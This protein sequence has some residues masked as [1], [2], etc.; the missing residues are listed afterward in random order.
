MTNEE[1]DKHGIHPSAYRYEALPELRVEWR[2]AATGWAIVESGSC[3]N[4][5]GKW[6]I[7]PQH[8]SRDEAF[9]QRCRFTLDE[10]LNRI[11]ALYEE[12]QKGG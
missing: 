4:R 5:E 6:E 3:L 10:A 1:M 12:G 7:E 8:S 2:G 9:F 11:T